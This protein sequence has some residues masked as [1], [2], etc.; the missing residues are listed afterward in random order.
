M[1]LIWVTQALY[2][3][4]YKISLVFSDGLSK[5]VDLKDS[6]Q[7]IILGQL[8]DI[9]LFRQFKLGDWS[10]EWPNGADISPEYLYSL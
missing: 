5:I 4:D 6:L 2:N 7:G 8:L 9:E 3:E 1:K 10:I